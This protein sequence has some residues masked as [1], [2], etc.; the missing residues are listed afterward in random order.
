MT[1]KGMIRVKAN[2]NEMKEMYDKFS[3]IY[4][5]IEWTENTLRKKTFSAI[6]IKKGEKIL[7]IG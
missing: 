5:V 2:E 1:E 3:Y 7:E 4:G 6:N